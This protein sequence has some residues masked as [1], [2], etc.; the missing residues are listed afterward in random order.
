MWIFLLPTKSDVI[1]AITSFLLMVKNVYTFSVK[2]LRT[3]NGCEFFNFSMKQLLQPLG[4]IHQSSCVFTPQQNGVADRRHRKYWRLP[5]PSDFKER[6]HPNFGE[7]VLILSPTSSTGFPL[8]YFRFSSRLKCFTS[9]PLSW[10][11]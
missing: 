10:L 7:N 3:D 6:L 4:I 8:Q 1:A 5:G 9:F 2:F 11:I